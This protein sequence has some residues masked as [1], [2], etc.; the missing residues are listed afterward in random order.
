MNI[1]KILSSNLFS[2]LDKKP[3]KKTIEWL[4][5]IWTSYIFYLYC[6][7]F[8]FLYLIFRNIWPIFLITAILTYVF[9]PNTKLDSELF[10][11]LIKK[12]FKKDEVE[13][14]LKY[15]LFLSPFLAVIIAVLTIFKFILGAILVNTGA[16]YSLDDFYGLPLII[17][18]NFVNFFSSFLIPLFLT[19]FIF[20]IFYFVFDK[21]KIICHFKSVFAHIKNL[22]SAKKLKFVGILTLSP[23]LLI[24]AIMAWVLVHPAGKIGRLLADYNLLFYFFSI[25]QK[26]FSIFIFYSLITLLVYAVGRKIL[27]IFKFNFDNK[28]ELFLFSVGVGFIPIMLGTFIIAVLGLLYAPVVWAYLFVLFIFSYKELSVIF[29]EFNEAKINLSFNSFFLS[30]KSLVFLVL[31]ILLSLN[32][33]TIFKPAPNDYDSLHT[34]FYAPS[35][36]INNHKYNTID[37][38]ENANMVQNAEF[39][40]AS[41][42]S[43]LNPEFIIHFSLLFFILC[44]I[45]IYSLTKKIYNEYYAVWALIAAYFIPCNFYFIFTNKIDLLLVFYSL[46]MLYSVFAW[47]KKDF[48]KKYLFIFGVFSGVG[49]GIKYNAVLLI[50]PLFFLITIIFLKNKKIKSNTFKHLAITLA[51]SLLFFLPWALKNQI[52]FNNFTYPIK[53]AALL[54]KNTFNYNEKNNF[55]TLRFQEINKLR[56]PKEKTGLYDFFETTW[57]TSLGKNIYK[58]ISFHNNLGFMLLLSPFLLLYYLIYNKK[59][60]AFFFFIVIIPY[61]LLWYIM[62]GYNLRN[63]YAGIMILCAASVFIILK[64]RYLILVYCAFTIIIGFNI[65][66]TSVTSNVF[67]LSG[68]IDSNAYLA[69]TVDYYD[70]AKYVNNLTLNFNEK[71]LMVGDSR[72]SFF[73]KNGQIIVD[74][75]LSN[76]GPYLN[77]NDHELKKYLQKN[78]IK[79][80]IYPEKKF[81]DKLGDLLENNNLTLENYLKKYNENIPSIYE[82]ARKFNSFLSLN[83]ELIYLGNYHNVYK[84]N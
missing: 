34:Y 41:T 5:I 76:I 9:G 81:T 73:I 2:F 17:F 77:I 19:A 50:A 71:I 6:Y 64:N 37:Y 14:Q 69:V 79:Y 83:T 30:F 49:M 70:D 48:N 80:I 55:T 84:L 40:Y 45:C 15:I 7:Y 44:L 12:I 11:K 26:I 57:K 82:D 18:S 52:Y 56:F 66:G 58:R 53:L 68:Q 1:I 78:K 63:A 47:Y 28:I 31:F 20:Y 21:Y 35:T 43:I 39:I 36:F 16:V 46:L 51:V 23:S 25:F 61:F 3:V 62:S 22:A 13:M 4:L 27:K 24:A 33:V 32:F 59:E 54:K 74:N 60:E 8:E 29:R 65:F 10:Q 42:L 67:Y 75:D 38:I 72:K